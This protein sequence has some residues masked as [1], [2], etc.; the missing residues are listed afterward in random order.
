MAEDRAVAVAVHGA[1]PGPRTG[2]VD[3]DSVTNGLVEAIAAGDARTAL[4]LLMERHGATVH[5]YC[6]RTGESPHVRSE[7]VPEPVPD[8]PVRSD[9]L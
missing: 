6:R 7:I 8:S 2:A 1:E 9:H 5:R 3:R 4:P